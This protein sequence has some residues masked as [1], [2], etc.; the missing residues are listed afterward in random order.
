VAIDVMG[1]PP[2]AP[3]SPLR[4]DVMAAVKKAAAVRAPGVGVAPQM[5]AGATDSVFYRAIGIS[6]YGVSGLWMNPAD[7]FAHGLDERVPKAAVAP[8]IE[9]WRTLLIELA[10]K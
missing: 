3:A 9:H 1:S 10:G 6:S 4:A 2:M 7:D 8:A 5:S